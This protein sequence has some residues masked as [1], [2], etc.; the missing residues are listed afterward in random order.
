MK[1]RHLKILDV[2]AKKRKIEVNELAKLLDVSQVTIRKDLTEL[3]KSKMLKREHGFAVINDS[4][5]I[6]NRL[7]QNFNKKQRIAKEALKLVNDNETIIIESGSCCSIFAKELAKIK[8]NITIV[9]NSVFIAD[10][11]RD[12]KNIKVILLGGEYQKESQVIIGSLAKECLKHFNVDKAFIGID[13]YTPETGFTGN[14]FERADI[15]RSMIDQSENTIIL[16]DSSKFGRK[17]LINFLPEKKIPIVITDNE[18]S[19]NYK[20]NLINE[21]IKVIE[22]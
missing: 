21:G 20:D 15:V 2:L 14:N 19:D 6:N 4:D 12:E 9:T 7:S 1:S 10:H 8:K 18:I 11:L 17:S 13:G 5:D 16:S 22:V 3:E